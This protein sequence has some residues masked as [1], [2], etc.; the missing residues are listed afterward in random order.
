MSM[1]AASGAGAALLTVS[2]LALGRN[3]AN[4]LT[5]DEEGTPRSVSLVIPAHNEEASI[6]QT[7]GSCREQTFPIDQIIVI[8]D[9]CS[10]ATAD[11]ARR[12][13]VVVIEGQGGSKAS[14]Q[15]LALPH[16][17]SD[18]VVA[19][20]ADATLSRDAVELMMGTLRGGCVGT[21]TSA[22]PRDTSTVYS[23]YRTLYHAISNGWVRPLQ[24]R[25]GRQM[26]L[27]GMAN[28]H[29]TDL[30]RELGGFPNDNITEDFNL[31]WTLHRR[32]H[33]VRFTSQAFV[34]TQ[35]PTSLAELLSQMH[36]W[37]AG[38]A[39]TM[40]RHRA[41]LTD[42]ASLVVVGTQVVDAALGGIALCSLPWYL[43]RHGC[44][45]GLCTWWSPLW[46]AVMLSSLGVAVRQLGW[47]TTAKCLPGWVVMQGLTGP[48]VT[49]WLLREW[50]LGRHLTTWTGRHGC[51][52][53]IT[54]MTRRRKAALAAGGL[55]AAA[56]MARTRLR[57]VTGSGR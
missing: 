6:A 30:L 57:R 52:P 26:V 1:F 53:A 12:L 56:F 47:R 32:A 50:L 7:I 38:F 45:R 5:A 43:A 54:P 27:S 9:N 2:A 3:S 39:Q 36:R 11:I 19:L 29:R 23:Q 16:I 24:D 48:L 51:R 40:V 15:N 21:C 33:P 55:A 44:T 4:E 49:W 20:D 31:T 35:E 13:G 14:A 17:T 8:A 25:L 18:A 34:Y 42:A 10:D 28:C 46:A 22:R 41:P 37:T